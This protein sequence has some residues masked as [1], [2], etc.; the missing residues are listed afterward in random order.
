[1]AGNRHNCEI[2]LSPLPYTVKREMLVAIIFGRFSNMTIWR[3]FN[4]M[5]SGINYSR[6]LF[7]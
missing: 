3:R 6:H 1:M 4:L 2:L 5:N 7:E